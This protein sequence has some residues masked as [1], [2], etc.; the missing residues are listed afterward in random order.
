MRRPPV[1]RAISAVRDVNAQRLRAW[2]GNES[3]RAAHAGDPY[4]TAIRFEDRPPPPPA[5]RH[6]RL[7]KTAD[8]RTSSATADWTDPVAR[9]GR[10]EAQPIGREPRRHADPA[11]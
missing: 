11:L 8:E 9:D 5:P 1:R 7:L 4:R 10:P 2:L 6:L 3:V